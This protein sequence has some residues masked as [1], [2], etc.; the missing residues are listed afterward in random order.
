VT[1]EER[2]RLEARRR[3]RRI[4]RAKAALI[5]IVAI[6]MPVLFFLVTQR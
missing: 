4:K 2:R 6:A 3:H 1:K 5:G